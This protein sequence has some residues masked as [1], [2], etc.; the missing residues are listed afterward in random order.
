MA[1]KDI[2][3][4]SFVEEDGPDSERSV[5]QELLL[6]EHLA[7][8]QEI[9]QRLQ[10]TH[11]IEKIALTA[12]AA[13]FAFL[14]GFD[15]TKLHFKFV[16]LMLWWAPFFVLIFSWSKIG[17][18]EF[19]LRQISEYLHRIEIQLYGKNGY[20][21]NDSTVKGWESE[22]RFARRSARDYVMQSLEKTFW[23]LMIALSFGVALAKT[24]VELKLV[25]W[26]LNA[27]PPA[28]IFYP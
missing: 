27:L 17:H 21:R 11:D 28:D 15:N 3:H 16:E 10:G 18:H 12:T 23:R 19:R 22:L 20:T 7:L 2:E 5:G 24:A 6:R 1:A 8:R 26:Q 13:I 4:D 14:I 9:L 25:S